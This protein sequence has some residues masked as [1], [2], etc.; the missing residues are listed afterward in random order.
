MAV[1]IRCPQLYVI[2]D[3]GVFRSDEDWLDA[4]KDVG[5]VLDPA[6][7]A[8]QVRVKGSC[9]QTRWNR[10][11]MAHAA[12]RPALDHGARIFVNGTVSQ[13]AELGYTGVHLTEARIP[14][15]PVPC[16]DSL[17]I[18]A[19][20]HS[21]GAIQ[22][23]YRAAVSFVVYGPIFRPKSKNSE[24]VG[25]ENLRRVSRVT[26]LPILALGGITPERVPSCINAGAAGV[27]CIT[28]VMKSNNRSRMIRR[29][30]E[31]ES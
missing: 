29:L 3:R 31:G 26:P 23:A 1:K 18:A 9:D 2:G 15:E 16:P 27:A 17:E 8:L 7:T 19:S 28:T 22:K 5:T 21:L 14:N 30:L 6:L 4:L 25:L 12:L 13:A 10:M 20:T 24:P 11:K